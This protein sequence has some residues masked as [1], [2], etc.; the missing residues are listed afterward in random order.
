MSGWGGREA[1]AAPSPAGPSPRVINAF[2]E[3]GAAGHAALTSSG[4]NSGADRTTILGGFYKARLGS[5][6]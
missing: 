4:I 2:G 5:F 1:P 3:A 6:Q